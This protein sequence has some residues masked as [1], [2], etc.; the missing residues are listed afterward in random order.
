[1]RLS[2]KNRTKQPRE[3]RHLE[4]MKNPFPTITI[5]AICLISGAGVFGST[6]G[7]L[8][9][10]QPSLRELSEKVTISQTLPATDPQH[11]AIWSGGTAAN[12][13]TRNLLISLWGPPQR[14][15]L[16]VNKTDVWDRRRYQE[17]AMTLKTLKDLFLSE[18][19]P[20][21]RF[22]N[23][24]Q[25]N[26]AYDAPCPKPVGQVIVGCD[27]FEGLEG[28]TAVTQTRNGVTRVRLEHEDGGG[29]SRGCP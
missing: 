23:Y 17:P 3:Y 19:A 6:R 15:T 5:L 16:S 10:T 9:E 13:N 20:T 24:Y 4:L 1:M 2:A 29:G 7:A 14:L 25:S 26:H 11:E 8:W 27:A 21:T 18:R 28:A 22:A 12:L